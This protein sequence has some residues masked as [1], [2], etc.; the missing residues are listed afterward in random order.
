MTKGELLRQI[1]VQFIAKLN[2]KTGWGRNEILK[3][4]DECVQEVT[5]L[6]L[7]ENGAEK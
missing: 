5:Y 3:V 6:V 2:A 7:D 4:Y 1:R